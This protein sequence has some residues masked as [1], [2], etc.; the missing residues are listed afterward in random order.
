MYKLKN[1]LI[2][3]SDCYSTEP[4]IEMEDKEQWGGWGGTE[5]CCCPQAQEHSAL[6]ISFFLVF[7]LL[8][9]SCPK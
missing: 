2:Y 4:Q 7:F 3:T 6:Y 5:S 8:L 1:E 9:P